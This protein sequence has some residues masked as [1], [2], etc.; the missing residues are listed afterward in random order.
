[1]ANKELWKEVLTDVLVV[2]GQH[3]PEEEEMPTE[4]IQDL[5][6][7]VCS[8]L[9]NDCLKCKHEPDEEL[10]NLPQTKGKV[11]AFLKV[12][13]NDEPALRVKVRICKHCGC[14]YAEKS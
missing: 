9:A 1:M 11:D 12:S 8:H 5:H 7:V 4:L 10:E 14:L 13:N 6:K 2:V 3:W